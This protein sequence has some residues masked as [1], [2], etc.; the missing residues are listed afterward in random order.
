MSI[1]LNILNRFLKAT[2][3]LINSPTSIVMKHSEW[4]NNDFFFLIKDC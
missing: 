4:F 3:N 1:R 2:Q